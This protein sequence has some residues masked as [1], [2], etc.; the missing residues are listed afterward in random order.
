[1]GEADDARK[2]ERLEMYRIGAMVVAIGLLLVSIVMGWDWLMWPRAIAWSVA[3]VVSVLEGRLLERLGRNARS[4]YLSALLF[5]LVAV[6]S[7]V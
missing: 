1:M 4:A 2:L 3:A 6:L 7:I 5:A